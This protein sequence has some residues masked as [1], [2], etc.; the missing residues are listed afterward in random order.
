MFTNDFFFKCKAHAWACKTF[1]FFPARA[2]TYSNVK[3]SHWWGSSCKYCGLYEGEKNQQRDDI[4]KFKQLRFLKA[5]REGVFYSL[6]CAQDTGPLWTILGNS[7]NVSRGKICSL[8]R[9]NINLK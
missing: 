9:Y 6:A 8:I 5:E 1:F 4:W 2:K 3:S 7:V